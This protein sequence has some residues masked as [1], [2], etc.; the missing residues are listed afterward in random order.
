MD[1]SEF[2]ILDIS[3]ESYNAVLITPSGEYIEYDDISE[4]VIDSILKE[5][6]L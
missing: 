4:S 5:N 3:E 1:G 6:N 2:K